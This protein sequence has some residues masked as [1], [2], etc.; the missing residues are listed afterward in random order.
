MIP[1]EL[2]GSVV[3]AENSIS[4]LSFRN[5]LENTLVVVLAQE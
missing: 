4:R 2:S 5:I 1:L 3:F